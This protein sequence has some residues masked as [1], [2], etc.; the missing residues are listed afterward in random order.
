MK[1]E[2]LLTDFIKRNEREIAR[3]KT[4]ISN[5]DDQIA[6]TISKA[7]ILAFETDL[8]WIIGMA[9]LS[10]VQLNESLP[11]TNDTP[12]SYMHIDTDTRKQLD[13]IFSIRAK[14]KE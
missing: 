14:G 5:T 13:E 2:Q 10:D 1:A 3:L 7:M 6:I 8:L 12:E 4:E 9:E 11:F